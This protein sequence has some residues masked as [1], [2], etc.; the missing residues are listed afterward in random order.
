M[1]KLQTLI[2]LEGFDTVDGFLVEFAFDS[3]VPGICMNPDCDYTTYYEPDQ[4]EGW[5]EICDTNTV[6]SG[7]LLAGIL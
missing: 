4:D 3:T 5:C 1:S 2:E 7:L 6:K